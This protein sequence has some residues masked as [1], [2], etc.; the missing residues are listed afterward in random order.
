MGTVAGI[1][2]GRTGT[3]NLGLLF[4]ENPV[5]TYSPLTGQSLVSQ[6]STPITVD[7][8]ANLI[9]SDWPI[10]SVLGLSVDRLTPGYEDYAMALNALIALDQLGAITISVTEA[11]APL[12]KTKKLE[13]KDE[14]G[15]S[16]GMNPVLAIT[17]QR[18]HP[19]TG[20]ELT[21][22][23]TQADIQDLWCR[24]V[25][26][27]SGNTDSCTRPVGKISLAVNVRRSVNEGG[28]KERVFSIRTRSAIGIVKAAT[29]VPAPLIAIV[30]EEK[31]LRII[32]YPWNNTDRLGICP[33]PSPGKAGS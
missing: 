30:L 10:T 26:A 13:N 32:D 6:I 4:Q 23:G 31:Y 21:E 27:I 3:A 17:L 12:A 24:L 25:V 9:N 15:K 8:L 28:S 14:S 5:I 2:T 22:T 1:G 20:G 33:Y 19:D 16:E 29:E 11:Q 18:F 7:S